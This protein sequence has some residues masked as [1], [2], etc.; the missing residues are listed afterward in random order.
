MKNEGKERLR[1]RV[2]I[3]TGGGKGIG[4]AIALGLAREGANLLLC[5]RDVPSLEDVCQE[6][7]REGITAAHVKADVSVEREVEHMVEEALKAFGKVD[8]LVNNAGVAGPVDL[9]TDID[10]GV[11]EEVLNI[12][13]TGMFL[14]SRAV[15]RHMIERRAGNLINLS[16]G[17][18]FRGA[19]VRSVPYTVSK[20]GVEGFTYALAVQMRSYG[21]CVNALRPGRTDTD[22]HRDTPPEIRATMRK[23]NG[24]SKLAV[25]LSLQTVET[26]TG[27]SIDLAEWEKTG[28]G[29]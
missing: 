12:N 14:S 15:L 8:I 28:K 5:G 23:P 20:W 3:V 22:I 29:S 21:I 18:G 11:W 24:V 10:K 19:L 27:E 2:A 25:F 7:R 26:M 17:A 1:G 16:S 4:R 13:L 6:V 9:I